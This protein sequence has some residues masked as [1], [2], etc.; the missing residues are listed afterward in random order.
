MAERGTAVAQDGPR[1]TVA[2]GPAGDA[3]APGRPAAPPAEEGTDS[4]VRP[5]RQRQLLTATLMICMGVVALE[6]TVVTTALPSVVGE[7]QGLALYP[8]VFSVYLL[9]STTSVPVYGKLAD[10]YGRKPL[11]LI[12]LSIFLLGTLLCGASG[13]MVQ[14]VAFRALQGL[15]AGA[16]L[17]LTLTV[18]SD[19]YSLRDRA[20][21]QPLTA[22]VWGVLS[23]T[24]PAAGAFITEAISWRWVFW[25]NVPVCLA[26][27]ALLAVF[28]KE[29][30]HPRRVAVDYAGAITLTLGLMAALLALLE[31][32]RAIPLDSLAFAA[33]VAVA[34]LLLGLFAYVERRAPDP[35]LPF[36]AFRL[37]VV[38]V[39][40]VGNMLIGVTLYGL[41]SYLPLFAQGV[42]GASAAGAS[43]VLTP[44]LVGWSLAALLSGR[45][46][47][48]AGFRTT[49]ILGTGLIALGTAPLLLIGAGTPLLAIA[50]P[51]AITG[52]G[53]G[54]ASPA[55]LLAPQSAV[56]WNLRGAVTS[57]T[58]FSR[59][60]AGSLGVA[61]LGALLNAR[62]AATLPDLPALP[63]GGTAEDLVSAVLNP[64][65]R[66]ALPA[67]MVQALSTALAG[68]LHAVYLGLFLVALAGLAMVLLFARS[69]QRL[70]GAPPAPGAPLEAS[71]GEV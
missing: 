7:L 20:R 8:W 19:I 26:A 2:P 34:V 38:A 53:L 12:G 66:A 30:V 36:S 31:G 33:L 15:G 67:E 25:V 5:G 50:A 39:S 28:L 55:F 23:L 24:G 16:V 59:T 48:R 60:I 45:L 70:G 62:L 4:L 71:L 14:L 57:S 10:V 52:A 9:T 69:S 51:M 18:L 27:L 37:R 44:L 61:L 68:S 29:R 43:A 58:Q 49:A 22:S 54:I 6:G 47:L 64:V 3:A 35:V 13:S 46:Y 40:N 1:R 56:P 32:G 21:V 17:P 42:Q 11:F 41:T 65:T 63:S